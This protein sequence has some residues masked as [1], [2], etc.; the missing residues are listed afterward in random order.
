MRPRRNGVASIGLLITSNHAIDH[1]SAGLD[2]THRGGVDLGGITMSESPV[3]VDLTV[4]IDEDGGVEAVDAR[5]LI[6]VVVLPVADLEGAVRTVALGDEAVAI[7]RLVVGEEPVGLL[8]RRVGGHRYIR[9]KEYVGSLG[10]VEGL[11]LGVLVD[12]KDGA[13]VAPM[14][15]VFHRGRP[16]HLVATAVHRH[17]IVVR[18]IDID[19]LLAGVVGILEHVGLAVGDVF[20]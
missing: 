9:G 1:L 16:H 3:A 5:H 10:R 12:H 8:A 2:G 18:A 13:V 17:Q 4:V 20:P 15:E 19:A 7:A 14:A 6:G 11:T